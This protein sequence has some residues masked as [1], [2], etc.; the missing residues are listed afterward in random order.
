MILILKQDVFELLDQAFAE[1][2]GRQ[3]AIV[4]AEGLLLL[5]QVEHL[6]EA[7]VP[8][9]LGVGAYDQR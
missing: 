4:K 5:D 8:V 6:E 7:L 9:F 3:Y 2:L 1:L